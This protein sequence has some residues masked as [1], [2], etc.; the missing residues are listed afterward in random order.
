MDML[1]E[2]MKYR[3]QDS[4]CKTEEVDIR[5]K[6]FNILDNQVRRREED[7]K[8]QKDELL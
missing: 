2:E 4:N 3:K 6:E 5:G 8:I 1:L 7:F